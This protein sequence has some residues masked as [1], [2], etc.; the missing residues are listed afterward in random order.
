M[1]KP[2]KYSNLKSRDNAFVYFCP[3]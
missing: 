2:S 1:L 3:N